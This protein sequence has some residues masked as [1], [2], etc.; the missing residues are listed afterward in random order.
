[1][2]IAVVGEGSVTEKQLEAV[3]KE[4]NATEVVIFP[5]GENEDMISAIADRLELTMN[6]DAYAAGSFMGGAYKLVKALS[7]K[8][9]TLILV[10]GRNLTTLDEVFLNLA[11]ELNV[12]VKSM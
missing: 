9:G 11:K 8:K 10:A 12:T 5:A 7:K 4:L 1:M 2:S 6:Y 3:V